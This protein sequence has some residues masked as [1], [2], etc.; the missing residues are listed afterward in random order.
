MLYETHSRDSSGHC[1]PEYETQSS[2]QRDVAGKGI[3]KRTMTALVKQTS[4]TAV[5]WPR[6]L[7]T[8]L[9]AEAHWWR[10]R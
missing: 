4:I 7:Q 1:E 9:A 10:L 8:F 3:S 5:A 6:S 2:I